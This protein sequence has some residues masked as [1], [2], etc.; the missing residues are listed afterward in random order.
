MPA[1]PAGKVQPVCLQRWHKTRS[2]QRP[3]GPRAPVPVWLWGRGHRGRALVE[4]D[5][6]LGDRLW[7]VPRLVSHGKTRSPCRLLGLPE[8]LLGAR[9]TA[10]TWGAQEQARQSLRS[11]G[12]L[13][14]HQEGEVASLRQVP[15]AG[16]GALGG[17]G[18]R[19][20]MGAGT[21]EHCPVVAAVYR[22]VPNHFI[23]EEI[24]THLPHAAWQVGGRASVNPAVGPAGHSAPDPRQPGVCRASG[25]DG[26][27]VPTHCVSA[28]K[29]TDSRR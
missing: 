17:P 29:Q 4:P 13:P 20:G 15:G 24:E 16:V 21:A 23:D 25:P 7:D 18:G 12:V 14:T 27:A 10:G 28:R 8:R 6:R 1:G 5:C 11:L 22:V 19:G 3:T 26:L 2:R 9:P